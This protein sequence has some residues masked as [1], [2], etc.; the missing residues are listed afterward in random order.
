MRRALTILTALTAV[1]VLGACSDDESTD[2]TGSNVSEETGAEEDMESDDAMESEDMGDAAT[3]SEGAMGGES[4]GD[5]VCDE[6]FAGQ[7]TP[8]AERADTQRD[9]LG[10]GDDLDPVSFSEVTLLSGRISDLVDSAEGDQS[11]LLERVNAPFQEVND[12]VIEDGTRMEESIE[13]PSVDVEDSAAAQDEF[14]A[15]CEG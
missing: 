15:A 11:A 3:E 6:F 5:P 8:L 2:D 9:L 14:M 1:T 12:A 4:M 7:G 13:I 10:T